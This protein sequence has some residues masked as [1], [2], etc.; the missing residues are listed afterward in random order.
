MVDAETEQILRQREFNQALVK[1]RGINKAPRR[2]LLKMSKA[3]EDALLKGTPPLE[4]IYVPIVDVM[5]RVK[6]GGSKYLA[7]TELKSVKNVLKMV[8]GLLQAKIAAMDKSANDAPQDAVRT[9]KQ[10]ATQASRRVNQ[11]KASSKCGV[12]R[13][14]CGSTNNL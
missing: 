3:A 2:G 9:S 1:F 8:A 14:K 13:V 7:E 5:Q 10:G 6:R 4:N 11:G 12:A